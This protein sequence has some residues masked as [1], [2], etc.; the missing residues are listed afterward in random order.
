MMKTVFVLKKIFYIINLEL[1]TKKGPQDLLNGCRVP[2]QTDELLSFPDFIE[3][4]D[5]LLKTSNQK[6]KLGIVVSN[7]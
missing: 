7:A 5:A 6:K 4:M 1:S 3:I 2:G